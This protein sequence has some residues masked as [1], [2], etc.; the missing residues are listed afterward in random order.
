MLISKKMLIWC[1]LS[2]L[3]LVFHSNFDRSQTSKERMLPT[4][5]ASFNTPAQFI[6][7]N[8]MKITLYRFI[9]QLTFSNLDEKLDLGNCPES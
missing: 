8:K 1:V 5:W 4:W 2:Q 7:C 9:I 6:I 3:V